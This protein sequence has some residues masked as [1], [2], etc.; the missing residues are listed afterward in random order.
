[1]SNKRA[2]EDLI[3]LSTIFKRDPYLG[4]QLVD[5]YEF[6]EDE[7]EYLTDKDT[8]KKIFKILKDIKDREK[9]SKKVEKKE[10]KDN[11]SDKIKKEENKKKKEK[12]KDK[13]ETK[14]KQMTLEAF[15][16]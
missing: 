5:F 9:K 2:R 1:M 4:A 15:F 3:Y 12:E 16:Q 6:T 10:V 7:V 14:G 8:T 13:K 11:K